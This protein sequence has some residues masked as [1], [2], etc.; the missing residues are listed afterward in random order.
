MELG[1]AVFD[2]GL[3][4]KGRVVNETA[5]SGNLRFIEPSRLSLR[6]WS[7]TGVP[8][9]PT[10]VNAVFVYKPKLTLP[11]LPSTFY[12][13][14]LDRSQRLRSPYPLRI[15]EPGYPV[16]GINGGA[17]V[18]QVRTDNEGVPQQVGVVTESPGLTDVT[19]SAVR[20]W[21]FTVPPDTGPGSRTAIVSIYFGTPQIADVGLATGLGLGRTRPFRTSH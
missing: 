4:S 21:R 9:V 1:V 12:V 3:D 20:N 15:V 6:D 11:D 17:V 18:V 10:H 14:G 8:N 19:V 2:V 7:F 13:P 5:L 16:D